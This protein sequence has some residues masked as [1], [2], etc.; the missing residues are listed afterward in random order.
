[1]PGAHFPSH[2]LQGIAADSR[3]ERLKRLAV[4]ILVLPGSERVAEE[5]EHRVLEGA[6]PFAVFAVHD[7][8]LGRMQSQSDL[9]YP[10]RECGQY[11]SGLTLGDAV[12]EASTNSPS[13]VSVP[14]TLC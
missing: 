3:I 9:N 7:P 5:G 14:R 4:S 2:L 11:L 6:T 13:G 12:Q 10:V 1:M 8:G